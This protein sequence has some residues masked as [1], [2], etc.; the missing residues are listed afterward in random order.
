MWWIGVAV[1]AAIVGA[2][3]GGTGGA[4][5]ALLSNLDRIS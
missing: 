4:A 3:A 1:N 2:I 5:S